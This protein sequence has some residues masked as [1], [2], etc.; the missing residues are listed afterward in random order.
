MSV[1]DIDLVNMF[2]KYMA[3]NRAGSS[4]TLYTGMISD[5][6]TQIYDLSGQVA[7]LDAQEET[8]NEQYLDAKENPKKF[9]LFG[10]LGVRT[11]QDWVFAFFYFSYAIFGFLLLLTLVKNSQRKFMTALYVTGIGLFVT[12]I[13]TLLLI[14]YA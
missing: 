10:N 13:I 12:L 9:G 6:R 7:I 5:L 8:Y 11:T 4:G 14:S 1:P 2:T 3:M